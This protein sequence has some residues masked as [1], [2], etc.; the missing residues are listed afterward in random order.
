M[1]S[2]VTRLS[3]IASITVIRKNEDLTNTSGVAQY[4]LS[5]KWE[6]AGKRTMCS[7]LLAPRR[8]RCQPSSMWRNRKINLHFLSLQYLARAS[9]V[10]WPPL[11]P[12]A[13]P[14][15]SIKRLE[16]NLFL[17]RS[18]LLNCNTPPPSALPSNGF[19]INQCIMHV[20]ILQRVC[21]GKWRHK[22]EYIL[23]LH[24]S[25]LSHLYVIRSRGVTGVWILYSSASRWFSRWRWKG[26]VFSCVIPSVSLLHILDDNWLLIT[27]PTPA[28][29]HQILPGPQRESERSF[30]L[31]YLLW[32][33]VL[34]CS[35]AIWCQPTF[36][37]P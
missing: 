11:S 25:H 30:L 37:T 20:L 31:V 9:R 1:T 14:P 29:P 6:I 12:A 7:L 27:D 5:Y 8:D 13:T 35:S 24:A 34:F 2:T 18:L 16:I 17:S 23:I 32:E 15:H 33:S 26:S 21:E 3:E 10:S 4:T 19:A 28:A 36:T 22:L